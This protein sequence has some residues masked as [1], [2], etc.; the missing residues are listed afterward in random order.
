M[1]LLLISNS[2]NPG[3]G[4]LEYP[5]DRIKEFLGD[6]ANNAI[7]IPYAAVTF[8]FDEY[9]EK[10]NARFAEIG[11]HVTGIHR[12]INPVEAIENADAIVVGGGNTWQLVKMLQEKGLMKVIR[13]KV[14]KGTPYIGWSAGSNIACPTLR[15][16]NDMPIVEPLKFKTL[17][18]VPFQIN[19]HYLDDHPANHGGE[20]REVR[21]KEFIEINRDIYVVGLR[22]ST[23][24]L[25]EDDEMEL[26][27]P[28]KARI[29][30][31]GQEPM[32]LSNEDDFSFLLQRK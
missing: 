29:F 10:V 3:E 31:Y 14:R 22:E 12:F 16:T 26:I 8:S 24:L 20:T 2:T 1:R 11:H 23:M 15:T 17:K 28:R 19:P 7:F 32:E 21:I 25:V 9:E 5:K 30:K 4:Y 6:K 13:K 27:G 18:L